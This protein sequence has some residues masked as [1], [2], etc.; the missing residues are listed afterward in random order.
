MPLFLQQGLLTTR[1]E[2]EAYSQLVILW[3]SLRV[4]Q[5]QTKLNISCYLNSEPRY[6]LNSGIRT[7]QLMM[8]ADGFSVSQGR[9]K[10]H[11]RATDSRFFSGL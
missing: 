2:F 1:L 3:I 6:L 4:S 9:D 5:L 10:I 11:N 7:T 8:E